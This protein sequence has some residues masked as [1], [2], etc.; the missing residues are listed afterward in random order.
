M[1]SAILV[2][3]IADDSKYSDL[4]LQSKTLIIGRNEQTKIKSTRCAREQ[5]WIDQSSSP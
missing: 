4:Q 3:L 5:G 2:Q 1:S